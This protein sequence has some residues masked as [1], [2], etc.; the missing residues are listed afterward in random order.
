LETPIENIELLVDGTFSWAGFFSLLAL[1]VGLFFLLRLAH[2]LLA[3]SVNW[4]FV[5]SWVKTVVNYTLLVYEPLALVLII[6]AFVLIKP[7]FHGLIL[8]LIL[9][10]AYKHL[11]NYFSGRLLLLQALLETGRSMTSGV[12]TG[13]IASIGRLGITLQ[14]GEGIA[15]LN[16]T[17]LTEQ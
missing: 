16:Y 8:L 7:L 6:S 2:R 12:Q 17:Q 14:T 3:Q 10:L 5:M 11:R 1:Q 4:G 15:F 9:L 13:T